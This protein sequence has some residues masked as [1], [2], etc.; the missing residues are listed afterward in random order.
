MLLAMSSSIFLFFLFDNYVNDDYEIRED[1]LGL[2]SL[3]NT[4][5]HTLSVVL[6]D[7]LTRNLPL[8][9]CRGQAYMMELQLCRERGKDWLHL[10]EKK[11]QQL[12]QFIVLLILLTSACRMRQG[13][14]IL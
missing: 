9:L 4:T 3:P 13:K 12:S 8:S 7:L 5:A 14:F 2:F 6:K 11:L 1:S 10:L